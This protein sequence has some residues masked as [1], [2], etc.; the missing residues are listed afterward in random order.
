MKYFATASTLAALLS[1]VAAVEVGVPFSLITVRSGSVLQYSS[2]TVDPAH[3]VQV[4][5]EGDTL[6]GKFTSDGKV[7]V[8]DLYLDVLNTHYTLTATGATFGDDGEDHLVYKANS[9]LGF[10]AV[11]AANGK[12]YNLESSDAEDANSSGAIPVALRI[13]Y[14]ASSTSTAASSSAAANVT[15][16]PATTSIHTVA[17]IANVTTTVP[18]TQVNGVAPTAVG[19]GAV[20]AGAAGALLF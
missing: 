13:E 11:P 20:L 16:A 7:Q 12:G 2:V 10:V 1:A 6:T 19:F 18:I 15:S 14:S 8:G 5:G 4:A 3:N 17:P 9:D